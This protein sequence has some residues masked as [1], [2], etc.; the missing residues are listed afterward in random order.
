MH[1]SEH[2]ESAADQKTRVDVC[3]ARLRGKDLMKVSSRSVKDATWLDEDDVGFLL[4]G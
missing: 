3:K 2:T 1:D 4:V